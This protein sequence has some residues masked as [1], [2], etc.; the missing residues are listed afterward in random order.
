M[1]K[2][3]VQLLTDSTNQ[4]LKEFKLSISVYLK[5]VYR[6]IQADGYNNINVPL[7]LEHISLLFLCFESQSL[8]LKH[9][10][11]VF[12]ALEQMLLLYKYQETTKEKYLTNITSILAKISQL[13]D[14][15]IESLNAD[16]LKS[17]FL[18]AEVTFSLNCPETHLTVLQQCM[19]KL[20]QSVETFMFN[21]NADIMALNNTLKQDQLQLTTMNPTVQ[22]VMQKL[23]L[24]GAFIRMI[25]RTLEKCTSRNQF[26][27][28]YYDFMANSQLASILVRVFGIGV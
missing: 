20:Y 19:P 4:D 24:I 25:L 14:L 21:L 15:G 12:G 10:L 17:S 5:Q 2:T 7:T 16:T 6:V 3:L 18:L 23:D 13:T 8:D 1:V 9:K 27:P 28:A 22:S 11:S 26:S